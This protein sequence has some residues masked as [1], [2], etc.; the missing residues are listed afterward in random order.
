MSTASK[1]DK[2][3]SGMSRSLDKNIQYLKNM[4]DMLNEQ[5]LCMEAGGKYTS[6]CTNAILDKYLRKLPFIK[7]MIYPWRNYDWGYSTYVEKYYEPKSNYGASSDTNITT[8]IHDVN[9]IINLLDGLLMDPNPSGSK[10][11]IGQ[12]SPKIVPSAASDPSAVRNDLVPCSSNH[13]DVDRIAKLKQEVTSLMGRIQEAQADGQ[14]IELMI[15]KA[16][17]KSTMN[18]LDGQND[19]CAILNQ[20]KVDSLSQ[21]VPY[22]D[23]FFQQYPLRGL[24]SSSFYAQVGYCPTDITTE[25]ECNRKGF[26]WTPNPLAEVIPKSIGNIPAGTCMRGKYAYIDNKPGLS[27]GQIK[28]FKGLIPSLVN[29]MLDL[30]PDKIFA[31]ASGQGVPGFAV[32]H[33]D[34][35]FV[36]GCPKHKC[37]AKQIWLVVLVVSMVVV[38]LCILLSR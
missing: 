9:A 11:S 2:A 16:T 15:L 36:G 8:I 12:P 19:S 37:V 23:P 28:N 22:D 7:N 26:Q 17:L 3:S 38:V 34:E 4:R 33:C 27:V 21:K 29:D 20:T 32:Q 25:D 24:N 5:N 10:Q 30:S 13:Y 18:A 14:V 6:Q 31:V 35:G 1:I